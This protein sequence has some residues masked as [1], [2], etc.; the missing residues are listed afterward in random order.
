MPDPTPTAQPKKASRLALAALLYFASRLAVV[1]FV[2][3]IPVLYFLRGQVEVVVLVGGVAV[4]GGL[5][6][7]YYLVANR[8]YCAA[9]TS[10]VL[11][12]NGNQKHP[13]SRRLAGLSH[14]AQV[15]WD[16]LFKPSYQCMYCNARCS[17]RKSGGSPRPGQRGAPLFQPVHPAQT[18]S[19]PDAEADGNEVFRAAENPPA[20]EESAVVEKVVTPSFSAAKIFP[21]ERTMPVSLPPRAAP[22]QDLSPADNSDRDREADRDKS[23]IPPLL[24][25]PASSSPMPWAK[26]DTAAVPAN[27]PTMN[28][29][30]NDPAA[31]P[32]PNPFLPAS[33]AAPPPASPFLPVAPPPVPRPSVEPA[34]PASVELP[35]I[36]ASGSSA[37]GT[38]PWT[39]PAPPVGAESPVLPAKG[40]TP[41]PITA[42]VLLRAPRPMPA[43]PTATAGLLKEVITALEEGHR[44]LDNAFKNL[45]E[46]LEIRLNA[47]AP[48]RTLPEIEPAPAQTVKTSLPE[49]PALEESPFSVPRPSGQTAPLKLPP[50][51]PVLAAGTPA[52]GEVSL[53]PMLRRKFQ[54]PEGAVA[55]QLSNALS[56]VFETPG[57]LPATAD[58]KQANGPVP[59]RAATTP[60]P[61]PFKVAAATAPV[62]VSTPDK[63]AAEPL[64]ARIATTPVPLPFKATAPTAPVPVPPASATGPVPVKAAAA[65]APVPPWRPPVLTPPDSADAAS[66]PFA[67]SDGPLTGP[68]GEPS[69]PAPFTFLKSNGDSFAPE[70]DSSPLTD[71]LDDTI[72]PWMQPSRG[73]N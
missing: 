48:G 36:P 10:P 72:L 31:A 70:V 28:R 15:A 18:A 38:P 9:C 56:E 62:P 55:Q 2:F 17:C 54:R 8:Q 58:N 46:K 50:V 19:R 32:G 68:A 63:S 3:A 13:Y 34:P 4:A 37:E 51:A 20:A 22:S 59:A 73:R 66:S 12:D 71:P 39:L 44:S 24:R 11:V 53:P 5:L 27:A 43:A 69:A 23:P 30:S 60:V 1:T 6:A 7:A 42:P 21:G 25:A 67:I 35:A 16:I 33:G 26:P 45:I 64:P 65:T 29:P 49:P 14:R 61:L 40:G 52:A 47:S 57:T 41:L